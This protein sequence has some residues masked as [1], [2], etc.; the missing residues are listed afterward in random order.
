MTI[1]NTLPTTRKTVREYEQAVKQAKEHYANALKLAK[2]GNQCLKEIDDYLEPEFFSSYRLPDVE[3]VNSEID[4]KAWRKLISVTG[5]S[6][7]F[8]AVAM[9]AFDKALDNNPPEFTE[10]NALATIERLS[11]DAGMMFSRGL[12]SIFKQLSGEYKSHSGF[13]VK[14]KMIVKN[15]VAWHGVAHDKTGM[16]NDLDRV[17]CGLTSREYKPYSLIGKL[18]DAIQNRGGEYE[19]NYMTCKFFMNGNAHIVIKDQGLI[20]RINDIIA[21]WYGKG[22]A[23]A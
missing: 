2:L 23:A 10:A 4:R 11:A 8:D 14:K 22:L 20:D 5:F 9:D 21:D 3:K 15:M 12:V 6:Q 19:D 16:I 18:T 1:K 13:K 7:I 17:L